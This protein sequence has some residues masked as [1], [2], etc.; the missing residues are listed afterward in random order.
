MKQK[1]CYKNP[2]NPSC[3]DL[4]LTNCLRSFQDTNVFEI[5]LSDF[6]KMTASVLKSHIPKQK[7][8]IVCFLPQLGKI[9]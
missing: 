7:P 6:H 1:T 5:G 9:P 2:H 8:N 4:I 3:I